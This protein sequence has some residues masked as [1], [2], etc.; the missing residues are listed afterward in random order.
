MYN[1]IRELLIRITALE[2]KMEEVLR[3]QQ[4]QVVVYLKDGRV[5]IIKALNQAHDVAETGD[6]ELDAGQQAA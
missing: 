3:K 4:E 1:K 6:L 5:R 2:D